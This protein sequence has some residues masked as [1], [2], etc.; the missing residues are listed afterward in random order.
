[1]ISS[2][3][4]LFIFQLLSFFAIIGYGRFFTTSIFQDTI[5]NEYIKKFRTIE[6]L[7]GLIS[8]GTLGILINFFYPIN[9]L[10]SFI[11]YI[12][13]IIFF[14]FFFIKLKNKKS[15]ILIYL[16]IIFLATIFSFYSLSNDDYDYHFLTIMNFKNFPILSDLVLDPDEGRRFAYNSHWLMLNS[17]FYITKFPV[18]LYVIT[19][20][21]YILVIYDFYSSFK[22]NYNSNNFLPLSYSS[23]VLVF[24]IGVLNQYKEYGTDLPGQ[25]ILL[26]IFLI[27]FEQ[28]EKNKQE[29]NYHNY[30]ILL[31]ISSL[32]FMLKI[33]NLFIFL[34]IGFLFLK[35]KNKFI[36]FF[37]SFLFFIP[38]VFWFIQNYVI[39]K[40]LI[41]PISSTC[42]KNQD[43][44]KYENFVI[45]VSAKKLLDI[46]YSFEEYEIIL[47]NYLWIPYWFKNFI[48]KY[49]ETYGI[50]LLIFIIFIVLFFILNKSRKDYKLSFIIFNKL[51]NYNYLMFSLIS[52]ISFSFW[53]LKAPDYRFGIIYNLNILLIFLIPFWY[54]IIFNN[55]KYFYNCMK[56]TMFIAVAFFLYANYDKFM[57]YNAK[58]E[59][60]YWPNI[61]NQKYIRE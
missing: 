25:I 28:S 58:F 39:S 46:S 32:A 17:I 22:R 3:F 9:D 29:N 60:L 12:L 11:I 36:I 27:F 53:F 61:V 6:F 49:L 51:K 5:N 40:C 43:L 7:F 50:Y 19:S 15:E 21:L 56:I 30:L 20:L 45:E 59:N 18:S 48:P 16:I 35:V 54:N 47:N 34:L 42:F 14:I 37:K 24:L 52:L 41:W 38:L 57:K 1:M 23:L 31:L 26:L 13:G 44:A 8:I 2:F 55:K 4:L 10:V 33:S